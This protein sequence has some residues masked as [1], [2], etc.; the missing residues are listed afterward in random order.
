[1]DNLSS[2]KGQQV[3]DL[4]E[5]ADASLFYLPPYRP[6]FDPFEYASAKLKAL[7]RKA[8]ARTIEGRWSLSVASSIPSRRTKAP[9]TSPS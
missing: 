6:E 5:A 7:P 4:I 2:H 3:R 9:I 1:M 8:A